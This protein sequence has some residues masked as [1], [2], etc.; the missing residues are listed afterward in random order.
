MKKSINLHKKVSI[1]IIGLLILLLI[2]IF[3]FTTIK[4]SPICNVDVTSVKKKDFISTLSTTGRIIPEESVEIKTS[5]SGKIILK[6]IK[7]GEYVKK[8]KVLLKIDKTPYLVALKEAEFNLI[9][10]ENSLNRLKDSPY[11]LT[12]AKNELIKANTNLEYLKKKECIYKELYEKK[13]I[14]L[15][16]LDSLTKEIKDAQLHVTQLKVDIEHYEKVWKDDLSEVE[17]KLKL[18]KEI[19]KKAEN[20]LKETEII[21]PING[22]I[23]EDIV[24]LK[25]YVLVGETLFK[26][27]N[28]DKPLLK[29]KI[30]EL[31]INRV[32][33]CL[34]ATITGE[35]LPAD[36]NY[37]EGEIM[38]IIPCATSGE[39]PYM[40]AII[41][42]K[43][44][45]SDLLLIP[46]LSADIEI[47]IDKMKDVLVIPQNALINKD[48]RYFVY[49]VEGSSARMKKVEIGVSNEV[50]V[51]IKK[52]LQE[53]EKIITSNKEKISAGVKVR[54]RNL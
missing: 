17:K 52:G 44:F 18:D 26:I 21:S 38:K 39:Y 2:P 30:E 20:E 16:E 46:N 42:L 49:T 6:T 12:K 35:W 8:D 25:E 5:V 48:G 7:E 4:K 11:E 13:S 41:E 19:L 28:L 9:K 40:E 43:K 37:L 47:T 50:E 33:P 34:K 45:P 22:V 10:D 32:K 29:A 1:L 23:I 36:R 24:G 53:G 3:I 27:M 51:V 15:P 54:E 14:S 31:D